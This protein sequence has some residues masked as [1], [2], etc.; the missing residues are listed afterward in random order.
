MDIVFFRMVFSQ[1][2]EELLRCSLLGVSY[3][4]LYYMG[5]CFL[6]V[7]FCFSLMFCP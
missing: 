3:E 4:V 6:F 2:F 7:I 5:I 1:E